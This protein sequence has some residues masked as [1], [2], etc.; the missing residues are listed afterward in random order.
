MAIQ[1]FFKK[2]C[3]TIQLKKD[4]NG[5]LFLIYLFTILWQ[6]LLCGK[7]KQCILHKDFL[8][9]QSFSNTLFIKTLNA[10]L[11]T[12]LYAVENGESIDIF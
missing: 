7:L 10:K 1:S 9:L 3:F 12:D 11:D 4:K 2:T 5:L 6:V 8:R